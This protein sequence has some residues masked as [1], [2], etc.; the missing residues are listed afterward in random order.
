MYTPPRPG[1]IRSTASTSIP[2]GAPQC[3]AADDEQHQPREMLATRQD[4]REESRGNEA[5]TDDPQHPRYGE[6]A[7]PR[8]HHERREAEP[9][10]RGD[11]PGEAQGPDGELRAAE[12]PGQVAATEQPDEDVPLAEKRVRQTEENGQRCRSVE[13]SG[14]GLLA[15]GWAAN[16]AW[17]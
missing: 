16:A 8:M 6:V 3:D 9:G 11:V 4:Q 7:A 1:R 17:A 14:H 10:D 12:E 15:P 2:P 13:K 5:C